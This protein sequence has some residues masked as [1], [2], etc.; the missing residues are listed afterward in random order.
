MVIGWFKEPVR[1]VTV[2]VRLRIRV[3]VRVNLGPTLLA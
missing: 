3:R 1:S 2:R